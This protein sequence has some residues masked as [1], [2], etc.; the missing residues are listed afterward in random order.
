MIFILIVIVIAFVE[1]L[2]KNYVEAKVQ[3][4]YKTDIFQGRITINKVYNKGAF[5]NFLDH[6][7]EIVKIV[8]GILLGL[9][10]LLFAIV[11]PKKGNK[12]F[13][14]GL[15]L[16]LG[17]SISN[18]SDRFLRGYVVDYFSINSKKF[19]KLKNVVFNLADM[20]IF[21]GALLILLPSVFSTIFKSGADKTT[22]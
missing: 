6:K 9:L 14:L 4:G 17:G 11:L 7:K 8:S 13:K 19:K 22:E 3:E 1:Y 18:V 2:I 15:S 21:L 12:V 16:I 5:L 10:L 20:A